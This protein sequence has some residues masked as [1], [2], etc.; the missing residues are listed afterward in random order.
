LSLID[1]PQNVGGPS[2]CPVTDI[3]PPYA[4]SSGSN[5]GF[6]RIGPV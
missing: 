2:A 3:M 4:C 1:A 5:P 6:I